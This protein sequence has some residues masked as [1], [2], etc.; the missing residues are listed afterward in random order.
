MYTRTPPR[1][2]LQGIA[3]VGLA[4]ALGLAAACAETTAPAISD[5]P[6][7]PPEG[8][9]ESGLAEVTVPNGQLLVERSGDIVL[10]RATDEEPVVVARNARLPSW[11]PDGSKVAFVKNVDPSTD[12]GAWTLCI[13]TLED[14][15]THCAAP[16]AIGAGGAAGGLYFPASWSPDGTRLAYSSF[17]NGQASGLRVLDV[18]TMSHRELTDFPVISPSWSPDGSRIALVQGSGWEFESDWS[19]SLAVIAPDGTG[20]RTVST[21]DRRYLFRQVTWSHSGEF[22]ALG[23]ADQSNCP[24]GC[25]SALGV[26]R[27]AETSTGW[28]LSSIW[29]IGDEWNYRG[30]AWSPDD[31]QVASTRTT[32][33][34]GGPCTS[35]VISVAVE[36]NPTPLRIPDAQ[37]PAWGR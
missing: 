4:V 1:S 7:F 25:A 22:L 26:A 28:K 10:F 23:L 9:S 17:A 36:G 21:G 2:T 30:I 11:S 3:R 15:D 19:G 24:M 16:A 35:S 32:C 29:V 6:Q 33:S 12:L 20:F 18:A 5:E 14:S 8:G 34:L 27:L 13:T 37:N 31:T